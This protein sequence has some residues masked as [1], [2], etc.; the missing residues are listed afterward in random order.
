MILQEF[1]LK[2]EIFILVASVLNMLKLKDNDS[3]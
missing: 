3:H 2:S 1:F